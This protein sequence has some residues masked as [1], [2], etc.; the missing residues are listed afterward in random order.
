MSHALKFDITGQIITQAIKFEITGENIACI[1]LW[2]HC[3]NNITCS[4]GII[5]EIMPQALKF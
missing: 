5:G 1:K 2:N 4:F 3:S